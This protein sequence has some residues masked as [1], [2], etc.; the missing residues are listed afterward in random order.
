MSSNFP[1]GFSGFQTEIDTVAQSLSGH[2]IIRAMIAK[3]YAES[4]RVIVTH[5]VFGSRHDL[6]FDRTRINWTEAQDGD[7]AKAIDEGRRYFKNL[8]IFGDVDCSWESTIFGCKVML[9]GD[10][11]YLERGEYA[12]LV[13]HCRADEAAARRLHPAQ[14]ERRDPWYA[15][16]MENGEKILEAIDRRPPKAGVVAQGFSGAQKVLRRW[17]E[18]FL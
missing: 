10:S 9:R 8:R 15:S 11:L 12:I 14:A 4:L 1:S 2:P 16:I 7:F 13:A 5:R 6:M 18:L 17:A 3:Q